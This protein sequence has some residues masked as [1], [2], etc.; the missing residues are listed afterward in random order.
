MPNEVQTYLS[1]SGKQIIYSGDEI[2]ERE[3]VLCGY[4]CIYYLNERQNGKT[5]L[6]TIHNPMFNMTDQYVNYQFIINY[7]KNI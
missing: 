5:I 7:F 4:W 1:S 6:E 3:S 2:Q